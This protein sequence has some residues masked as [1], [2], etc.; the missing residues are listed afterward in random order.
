MGE[1]SLLATAVLTAVAAL[2]ALE[3]TPRLASLDRGT[4]RRT[5]M[6]A[7]GVVLAT[8]AA[9][10]GGGPSPAGPATPHSA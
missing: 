4:W 5:P 8:G 9:S 2:I 7:G 6:L 10:A 1:V 3:Q